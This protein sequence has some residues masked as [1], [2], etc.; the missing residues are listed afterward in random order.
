M[1]YK[2]TNTYIPCTNNVFIE[3]AYSKS[4]KFYSNNSK[5][6]EDYDV[7]G[8]IWIVDI[9]AMSNANF[10]A[11]Q[12]LAGRDFNKDPDGGTYYKFNNNYYAFSN[13]FSFP[14]TNPK[15]GSD[16]HDPWNDIQTQDGVR[17]ITD[18]LGPSLKRVEYKELSENYSMDDFINLAISYL[19]NNYKNIVYG[20]KKD[21]EWVKASL[22]YSDAVSYIPQKIKKEELTKI[23]DAIGKKPENQISFKIGES[24]PIPP[25][26]PIEDNL[27]FGE[28]LPEL[29]LKHISHDLDPPKK[30]TFE[31]YERGGALPKAQSVLFTDDE[32]KLIKDYKYVQTLT[33]AHKAVIAKLKGIKDIDTHLAGTGSKGKV[34]EGG[35]SD[36]EILAS[37]SD[38]EN[39]ARYDLSKLNVTTN[40]DASANNLLD[41]II[42]LEV[43]D[44]DSTTKNISVL[45]SEISNKRTK[46]KESDPN[47]EFARNNKLDNWLEKYMSKI[48]KDMKYP[49]EE[50]TPKPEEKKPEEPVQPEKKVDPREVVGKFVLKVKSG[51]GV[52]IGI[53]EVDIVDGKSNFS[54]IEFDQPGDYILTVSSTSPEVD[55]TEIS[56]NV[57]PPP[58]AI[59][60]DAKGKDEQTVGTRPIISQIDQPNKD[61]VEPMSFSR[62][63]ADI[64]STNLVAIG[65]GVTPFLNY[66]GTQINDRDI[67]N[68]N[69][70][71]DDMIPKVSIIFRDTNGM[72][73]G[74]PPRDDTNFEI[75]LQ[76][77]SPDLK[78]IHLKFKIEEFKKLANGSY[79]ILG[80]LDISKLYRNKFMVNRGT[81]FETLREICKDLGLGFNSNIVNTNDNMPWRNIGDK[82]YKFMEDIIKH[83]YI[84]D[85]SFMGGYIDYYYC[86]NYVDIEKEMKRD[87]SKDMGIDTGGINPPEKK[88]IDKISKLVLISDPGMQTSSNFFLKIAERNEASKIGMEQGYKT[89]TKFY[90]KFKKMFL[91][92]D[93]DSTTTDGA[94]THILKGK[95]GDKEAFDNNYIT[96]YNG[97]IDTDNTHVNYNYAITQNN[98]NL[99]S[100]MKNQMDIVLPNP[101]W[102]LYRYQKIQVILVN[103]VPSIS[104]PEAILWRY[105]GE[106]LIASI[107][108]SFKNGSMTQNITLARKEMGKNPK[109]IREGTKNATKEKKEEKH[110]NPIVGTPSQTVISKP[111]DK[112]KVGDVFT[113][114]DPD[115]QRYILTITKISENG[116]DVV[117]T[118]RDPS[119][120]VDKTL[121]NPNTISGMSQSTT[122]LPPKVEPIIA[123]S[124]MIYPYPVSF[125]KAGGNTMVD[126]EYDKDGKLKG[127][128]N[129][130]IVDTEDFSQSDIV[131][132]ASSYARSSGSSVSNEVMTYK[133]W[134][135]ANNLGEGTTA[136]DDFKEDYENYLKENEVMTYKKWLAANNLGQGTT[137]GDDFK[138][139]Y[140]NYLKQQKNITNNAK[141]EKTKEENIEDHGGSTLYLAIKRSVP[142]FKHS[143][144]DAPK[145]WVLFQLSDDGV[146]KADSV[147]KSGDKKLWKRIK[148]RLFYGDEDKR[149]SKDDGY[150]GDWKVPKGYIKI[151]DE[152][153]KVIDDTSKTYDPATK[154][155]VNSDW[156]IDGQYGSDLTYQWPT[157]TPPSP[158]GWYDSNG[159][160][161]DDEAFPQLSLNIIWIDL[162]NGPIKK[163]SSGNMIFKKGDNG[164]EYVEREDKYDPGVYTIEVK[165]Y[166]PLYEKLNSDGDNKGKPYNGTGMWDIKDERVTTIDSKGYHPYETKV[167]KGTFTIAKK[168]KKLN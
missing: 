143:K 145:N 85:E 159:R 90:D 118:L 11:A 151:M 50:Y 131:Y 35:L 77:K 9:E 68:F 73:S 72:I 19:E 123:S 57:A 51:P 31:I 65:V 84:S 29:Y 91:V 27:D 46:T 20:R 58:E 141:I 15:D 154:L 115:K 106:W 81:S 61:L 163:D 126:T 164:S 71:H 113:V 107:G 18:D 87:I 62:Q 136:G 21:P 168:S 32:I 10:N 43:F 12:S 157:N 129:Q 53:N 88:E 117:A 86:F 40:E 138:E 49:L 98:I 47:K 109:E 3:E 166:V 34:S 99:D 134:L 120:V 79:S 75:F 2:P 127:D 54:G 16:L 155:G 33:D 24:K 60:Q 74:E 148:S 64:H 119:V 93:V 41:K 111:N 121:T 52:I 4:Y 26:K 78:S 76:S 48:S 144:K 137:A 112:Y 162:S 158:G 59:A 165:Y 36:K 130:Y 116:N 67:Q 153:G 83:S 160:V 30:I 152:S 70:Y 28:P 38:S 114:Q 147:G 128:P 103:Q 8:V 97:K 14:A 146:D 105:S 39:K 6:P 104:D 92:F 94:K 56:V 42:D 101:N 142:V 80:S 55:T 44:I 149:F 122:P 140:E 150:N 25:E 161:D 89:K 133:K 96:K 102:N 108:Y 7:N 167:L 23:Y 17:I 82:Q 95:E 156:N 45:L 13:I 139:D 5:H 124:S 100:M 22:D 110:E 132:M 63:G 66:N 125:E 135:A 37:F 69:L 1:A